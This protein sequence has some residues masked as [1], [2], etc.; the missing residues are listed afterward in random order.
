GDVRAAA[1][2]RPASRSRCG[3]PPRRGLAAAARRRPGTS[4]VRHRRRQAPARRRLPRPA[5]CGRGG[6]AAH[7]G[8]RAFRRLD[9]GA[10]MTAALPGWFDALPH[11]A[12]PWMLLA[13][14]L[15]WLARRWL[16]PLRPTLA[17]LRVPWGHRIAG[18]AQRG[19]V[20]AMRGMPPLALLA[21]C[22]L[23]VAAARPQQPGEAQQPP[24]AGREL[25][26]AVD[27][28][29][30]MGE[31]DMRLGGQLVDRLTAAKAVISDFL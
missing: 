31:E 21:W 19:D 18:I 1:P 12:W 17:A 26:L 22:L 23:C 27:L 6:R 20:V 25:M 15:P 29:G 16:P 4:G 7:G 9:A 13:L 24:A 2:R 3:H 10:R 8:A 14:P 28:S 30:S 5:R 11:L